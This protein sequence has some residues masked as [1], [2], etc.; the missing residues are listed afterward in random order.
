MSGV[1]VRDHAIGTVIILAAAILAA[2]AIIATAHIP[3]PAP[4]PRCPCAVP[5]ASP[6]AR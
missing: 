2:A 1:T 6:S 4:K 5:Y 3:P